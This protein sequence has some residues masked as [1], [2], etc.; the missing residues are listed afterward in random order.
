VGVISIHLVLEDYLDFD[1]DEEISSDLF[2]NKNEGYSCIYHKLELLGVVEFFIEDVFYITHP[3]PILVIV[4]DGI[5]FG[6]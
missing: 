4:C 2:D 3:H 6:S 1:N 5:C